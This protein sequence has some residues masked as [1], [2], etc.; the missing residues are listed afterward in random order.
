MAT[1]PRRGDQVVGVLAELLLGEL[2][3]EG[4]VLVA[5]DVVA[6][7]EDAELARAAHLAVEVSMSRMTCV[8][9]VDPL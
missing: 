4:H 8:V 1:M 3:E 6:L 9:L 5:E 7:D 2:V